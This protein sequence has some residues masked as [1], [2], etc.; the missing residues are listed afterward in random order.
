MRVNNQKS[1]RFVKSD[2][3][4]VEG[5]LDGSLEFCFWTSADDTDVC[6]LL[7]LGKKKKKKN[8]SNPTVC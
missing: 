4:E 1:D 5:D 8:K 6:L 2:I 3:V 7:I